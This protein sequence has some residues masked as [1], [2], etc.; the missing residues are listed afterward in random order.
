MLDPVTILAGGAG[1]LFFTAWA[2][3]SSHDRLVRLDE[4]CNTAWADVDVQLKH[5]HAIVPGLVEVTRALATHEREIITEVC[6]AYE[7]IET[8]SADQEERLAAEQVFGCSVRKLVDVSIK[9]PEIKADARFRDLARELAHVEETI[10]AARRFYNLAVGEY[11]A[12]RRSA[13]GHLAG[14]LGTYRPRQAIDLGIDR[15]ALEDPVAVR[16]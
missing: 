15:L 14:C 3:K 8:E 13:M 5:R 11:N 2:V 9:Y 7:A 4:R 16:L 1:V 10:T 12:V 6:R